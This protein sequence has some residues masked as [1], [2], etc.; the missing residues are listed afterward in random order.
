MFGGLGFRVWGGG[1]RTGGWVKVALWDEELG[2]T[3]K[4]SVM[5]SGAE[6]V[7]RLRDI[8]GVITEQPCSTTVS[9]CDLFCCSL[10]H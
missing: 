5:Q 9:A 8:T 2:K 3:V 4:Q 1:F 7:L 6:W 10:C